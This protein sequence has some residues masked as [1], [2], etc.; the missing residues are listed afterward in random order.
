MLYMNIVAGPAELTVTI[1]F[2]AAS[3]WLP[4]T[5]DLCGFYGC[6]GSFLDASRWWWVAS[7]VVACVAALSPAD[8]DA[9]V[10]VGPLCSSH[11][12]LFLLA[13]LVLFLL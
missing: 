1:G 12:F 6:C 5:F 13:A 11:G 9:L 10:A 3:A 8:G 2:N 4:W 7:P